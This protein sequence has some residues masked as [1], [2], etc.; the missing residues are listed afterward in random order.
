MTNKANEQPKIRKGCI[1]I[2]NAFMVR[3][4][5]YTNN[6]IPICEYIA[7]EIPKDIIT[8]EEAKRIY[9][10]SYR[11]NHN[12][13]YNA[14]VCFYCDDYKF[15]RMDGI[16]FNPKKNYQILS[17]FD[18]IIEPDFSTCLDFPEPIKIYNTFRMRAYSYWYSNICGKKV[19]YNVRWG[20]DETYRYCFD[21]TPAFSIVCI[22][23]VGSGLKSKC[24]RKVFE[25]G[26]LRFIKIK[27]PTT[28]LVYGSKNYDIFKKIEEKG[29]T[30]IAFKSKTARDFERLK[31]K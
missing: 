13:H 6:D 12:F 15:D 18:G 28:I 14:Y 11:K 30:V 10:S 9:S 5:F 4:A 22:G 27:R 17:H 29:I 1:D 3:G 8:F 31:N 25:E 20:S 16:W 24:N 21:G 2:W 7:D 23:T 26:I 19:I